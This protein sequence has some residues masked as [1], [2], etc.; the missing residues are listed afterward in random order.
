MN[1]QV[2]HT[3]HVIMIW[4]FDL[5]CLV[6]KQ[7]GPRPD[8]QH[9]HLQHLRLHCLGPPDLFILARDSSHVTSPGS[10]YLSFFTLEKTHATLALPIASRRVDVDFILG[11]ARNEPP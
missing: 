5:Q 7:I 10:S 6:H 8:S 3:R 9:S 1:I 2:F 4:H 11:A